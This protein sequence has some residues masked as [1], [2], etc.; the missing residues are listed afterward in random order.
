MKIVCVF[1]QVSAPSSAPGRTVARSSPAQT[2]WRATTAHTPARSASTARCATSVSWGATTWLN[3]PDD[4]QASTPACCRAPARPRDA[5]APC[6]CLPPTL[7]TRALQGC[8]THPHTV[9][10]YIYTY[11]DIYTNIDTPICVVC[12]FT[13]ILSRQTPQP[14]RPLFKKSFYAC[15]DVQQQTES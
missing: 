7:E 2:S 8:E 13:Q 11:I 6:R 1:P 4:T 9:H 3:T 5:A 14:A 12:T 15:P 10:I